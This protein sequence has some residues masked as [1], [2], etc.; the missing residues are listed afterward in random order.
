[1]NDTVS[2]NTGTEEQKNNIAKRIL[3]KWER[4]EKE[5]RER[6]NKENDI[7]VYGNI[8]VTTFEEDTKMFRY[9]GFNMLK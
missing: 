9:A 4:S 6:L 8:R 1:M 2:D 3:E 5:K 7:D